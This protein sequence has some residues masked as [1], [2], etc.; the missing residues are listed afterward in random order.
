[1]ANHAVKIL[2]DVKVDVKLKIA[3][4]WATMMLLFAYGDIFGYFRPGLIEG[5]IKGTV[6]GN[7]I[8]QAFLMFTAVYVAIP[9]LMVFL[10]L[11]LKPGINRLANIVLAVVYAVSIVFFCIGETW[12]YYIFMSALELAALAMIAWYAWKW[13]RLENLPA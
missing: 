10:S 7:Q 11:V 8:D 1:M 12:A 9:S 13:P 6:A 2:E 4:L 5:I 3:A